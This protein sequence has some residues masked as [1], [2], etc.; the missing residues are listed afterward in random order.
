MSRTKHPWHSGHATG[1]K[2]PMQQ[3]RFM[4]GHTH[5]S[6]NC[7]IRY[8]YDIDD[9]EHFKNNR[10][11]QH[12]ESSRQRIMDRYYKK[13]VRNGIKKETKSIITEE[14]PENMSIQQCEGRAF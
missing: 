2:I 6:G 8:D 9:E 4:K 5:C 1:R 11:E 3:L 7:T 13:K 12:S 10:P 14:I